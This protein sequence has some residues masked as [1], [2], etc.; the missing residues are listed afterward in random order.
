MRLPVGAVHHA[1]VA[2]DI[3]LR[4]ADG[5]FHRRVHMTVDKRKDIRGQ[6]FDLLHRRR[7]PLSSFH[8]L[9]DAGGEGDV[10]LRRRNGLLL[11]V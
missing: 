6:C 4:V 1:P 10:E 8:R 9:R 7:V 2:L 5:H 3:T 11:G